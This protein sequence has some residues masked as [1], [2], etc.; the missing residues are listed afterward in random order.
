MRMCVCI[1]LNAFWV[2]QEQA[3]K[4]KKKAEYR[5]ELPSFSMLVFV[6]TKKDTK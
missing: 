2:G 4:K 6:D 3:K 5:S 1:L